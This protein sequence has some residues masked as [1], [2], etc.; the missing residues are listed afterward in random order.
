MLSAAGKWGKNCFQ[1]GHVNRTCLRGSC[2]GK[3]RPVVRLWATVL[4]GRHLGWSGA[5]W[6]VGDGDPALGAGLSS[7]PLV[8]GWEM[9]DPAL[10]AGLSSK[11]LVGGWET[12]TLPWVLG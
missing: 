2:F 12:G 5:G 1:L 3:R 4:P 9:L 7:E 10:G 11:P 6:W 8:N